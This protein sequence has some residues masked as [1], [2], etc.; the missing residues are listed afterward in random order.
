M[1]LSPEQQA[2][3]IQVIADINSLCTILAVDARIPSADRELTAGNVTAINDNITAFSTYLLS[4]TPV[5]AP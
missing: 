3:I 2:E 5:V 4:I 1:A